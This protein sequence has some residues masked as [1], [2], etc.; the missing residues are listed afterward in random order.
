MDVD[1]HAALGEADAPGGPLELETDRAELHGVIRAHHAL[2]LEGKDPIEVRAVAGDE[3]GPR[4]G[5]RDG[6]RPMVRGHPDP[7]EKPIGGWHR[8]DAAQAE[9][10]GQAPLPGAQEPP[11]PAPREQSHATWLERR[12]T[13]VPINNTLLRDLERLASD[14]GIEGLPSC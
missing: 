14:L 8:A 10:L 3:G 1:G 11:D 13:S 12:A 2:A 9:F 4:L 5:R 6:P 7:L